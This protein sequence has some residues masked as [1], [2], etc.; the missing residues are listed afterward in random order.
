MRLK[1][2]IRSSR[3]P[4]VLV[5]MA[6]TADGKIATANRAVHS[7]G[8]ARDLRQLYE[9]RATA[10]AV[11]CGA[12]TIEI[13]RS[14]LDNGGEPFRRRRLRNGLAE[15][16]L[17]VIVS[18]SGS[19]DPGAEIFRK[20]FSPVI[21]LTT[22]RISKSQR[23]KLQAAGAEVKICGRAQINF[24]AALHWLRT[25]WNVKRL[26][27]EGGGELNA[28]MFRADL[29]DEIH[30]TICPEIL[31]GRTAPTIAEGDGFLKL[32]DAK[33]FDLKSI[34]AYEAELFTTFSRPDS[35]QKC[36]VI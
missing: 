11:M 22:A 19:I 29:V 34:Y 15:H 28:A 17:R 12:R 18:G 21:V 1:T 14:I 33:K 5:N 25:K 3:R 35:R 24:R 27:C 8:S 20:M 10:D 13:S 26:L 6:M 36:H 30:L 9:L 7:F 4:F 32:A 23:Q 31:G 16:N 2:K